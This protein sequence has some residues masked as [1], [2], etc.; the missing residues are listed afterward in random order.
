MKFFIDTANISEIKTAY[1]LGIISGVTTNPSIIAKEGKSFDQALCEITE[2]MTDGKIFAEVI[3][4][5][6]AGMIKEGRELNKKCDRMVIK[7]PMCAEGL[8]A[9]KILSGEDIKVC[10]TLIFS[11]TQALLAANAGACY[12]APF[13]GRLDD[14]GWDGISL[15][16]GIK[17]IFDTQGITAQTVAASTRHPM[18]ISE[19]AKCGC[20]IATVPY[21]VLIQMIDNPL[22]KAGL[23]KFMQDWESVPK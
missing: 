5:D 6:A 22:T 11:E 13:V 8:K 12:V 18:H 16:A 19:L 3:A 1:D 4:L 10:V 23:E 21:K 2:I 14:I 17:E 9:V 7:I 20:D 15:V